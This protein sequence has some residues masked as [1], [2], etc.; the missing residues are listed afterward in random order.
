MQI[1]DVTKSPQHVVLSY[2]TQPAKPVRDS[3]A[4]TTFNSGHYS[5]YQ[6]LKSPQSETL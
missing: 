6:T 4:H 1:Y 2:A 3:P 5:S